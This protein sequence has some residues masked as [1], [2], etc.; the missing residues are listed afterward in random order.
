MGVI[1]IV[2]IAGRLPT[3]L[4]EIDCTG[5]RN[6]Y[7]ETLFSKRG[8]HDGLEKFMVKNT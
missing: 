3:I 7:L 4:L 6:S 5:P 1:Y 2:D 8:N